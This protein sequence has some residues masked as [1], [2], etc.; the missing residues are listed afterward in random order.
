M[1]DRQII[2]DLRLQMSVVGGSTISAGR[3]RIALWSTQLCATRTYTEKSVGGS[4]VT[5][6][7]PKFAARI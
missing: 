7:T 6:I 3:V 5:S 2:I 4:R 1:E